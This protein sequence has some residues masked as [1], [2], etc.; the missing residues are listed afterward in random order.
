MSSNTKTLTPHG[1]LVSIGQAAAMLG[2][3]IDTVRRWDG[4][5]TL[6]SIRL[7]GKNR[8]FDVASLERQKLV[9]PLKVS[10]AAKMLDVS[11][12]TLRRLEV[13]GI[14]K[15]Q[16]SKNGERLYD[17]VA[18]ERLAA[19][20]PAAAEWVN[21]AHIPLPIKRFANG[22]SH[23][24]PQGQLHPPARSILNRD[25]GDTV[26]T[27]FIAILAIFS[28]ISQFLFPGY[29]Q[30]ISFKPYLGAL[31]AVKTLLMVAGVL[32]LWSRIS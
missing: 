18:V 32:Y 19:A 1:G 20:G 26:F 2:V 31:I 3:S 23:S 9:K 12:S 8:Y 4:A 14:I 7:D 6:K 13:K 25:Y 28:G 27:W 17:R 15:A 21:T 10:E 29:T 30:S 22:E 5:G 24:Q 11:A 16:R